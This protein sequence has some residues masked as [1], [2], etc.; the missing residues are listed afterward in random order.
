[1]CYFIN[2]YERENDFSVSFVILANG[3]EKEFVASLIHWS[4]MNEDTEW[5]NISSEDESDKEHDLSRISYFVCFLFYFEIRRGENLE[6]QRER[7]HLG[8]IL[9]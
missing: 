9:P 7:E 5:E 6:R 8:T 4:W 3:R 1:M 2:I